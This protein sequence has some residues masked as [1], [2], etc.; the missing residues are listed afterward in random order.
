[1]MHAP[2]DPVPAPVTRPSRTR[3][4]GRVLGAL[5]GLGFVAV[6]T[7][8]CLPALLDPPTSGRTFGQ[9]PLDSV[10]EAADRATSSGP[11]A[12][13][14]LSSTDLAAMM[15]VPTY[16]EAGGPV[17]AP[18]TMSRWDNVSVNANNANLFAFGRTAVNSPY[19]NAYFAPGAGLWAFDSA[20]G[21]DMTAAD[22]IDTVTSANQA[23]D[24]I[25]YRWCNAPANR[26]ATPQLRRQYAWGPWFG[27]SAGNTTACEDLY[28]SI[29][30]NG[31]VNIGFDPSV[32]RTGGMQSR[33]CSIRGIGDGLACAYINPAFAEGSRG[34]QGGTYDGRT[35]YVTP[36]PKPFYDVRAN[37]T[38]YRVWLREDT[39][40]AIDI[41]A[42]KPITANART[43]LTWT[44]STGL[45]DVANRRGN[46]PGIDPIGSFDVV[47]MSSPGKVR[48]EGWAFDRDTAAPIAVHVYAGAIG[49]EG[50]IGTPI[51]AN[52]TRTDVGSAF[53]DMGSGHGFDAVVPSPVGS[54]PVCVFAINSGG[55][56]NVLLG[57]RTITVTGTPIGSLD[58]VTT[59]PGSIS[60]AGWVFVPGDPAS[61]AVITVDGA[62]AARLTRTI[63]R[64]DVQA[65]HPDAGPMAGFSGDI[66]LNGGSHRVCL[67]G[68]AA[69]DGAL[70]CRTITLPTGSPFGSLDVVTAGPGTVS[71]AGW[72]IDPDTTA[73]TD[74]HVWIDNS[75]TAVH[76]D[77]LRTD[78]GAAFGAYGSGHGFNATIPMTGGSHDV[79]VFGFNVGGGSNSLLG[80]RTVVVPT[81]SPFG[82]I[83]AV[84]RTPGG[85]SV[86]GWAIDPDTARP[87]PVHVYVGS[88]GTAITA[89]QD[90]SD[91]GAVYAGYGSA[92]GF[93]ATLAAPASPVTVCIFAIETVGAGSNQL[94]GCRAI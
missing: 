86:A 33:T 67:T 27:C 56:N 71:V 74:A 26:Q 15:I 76:A 24:T 83:D 85:V 40:Y 46:C 21:W 54:Q 92:H 93:S 39:G 77:Q 73:P 53:P 29:D 58:V 59:Q 81:G 60:V 38:E 87:I 9:G 75:G 88:V 69:P 37:G 19:L 44:A 36:L 91:V 13:C 82:S 48:V 57:C 16:F 28:N 1:M 6:L 68:G 10:R 65:F 31:M 4:L 47:S 42:S 80:C 45:C 90:R 20:G 41:T 22:A 84:A 61:P 49:A 89:D 50:S 32:T 79:C 55:G 3:H 2:D 17:P 72:V 63:A 52:T 34:W 64:S 18:M 8:G 30:T 35:N 12:S 43:S 94:L 66:V 70:G 5:V 25:A 7:T 14:G 62:P 23:A 78:V 11:Y 51:T